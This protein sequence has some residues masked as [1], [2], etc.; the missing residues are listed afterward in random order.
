MSEKAK[1]TIDE[2]QF[3]RWW[4]EAARLGMS[5]SEAWKTLA[6]FGQ[7]EDWF[8]L[9]AK[10]YGPAHV[11]GYDGFRVHEIKFEDGDF[12]ARGGP[13][14]TWFGKS[15]LS[16]TRPEPK[17]EELCSDCPPPSYPHNRTR[18]TTC[19]RRPEKVC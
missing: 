6:K 15:L 19:P 16:P 2:D 14:G 12:F 13:I 17:P 4:I 18:C 10:V 5:P 7:L 9:G 3:R 8:R 1:L 11:C